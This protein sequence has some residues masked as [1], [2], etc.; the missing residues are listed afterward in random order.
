MEYVFKIKCFSF[1][2]LILFLKHLTAS[3]TSCT[4]RRRTNQRSRNR[5]HFLLSEARKK[6]TYQEVSKYNSHLPDIHKFHYLSS[7]HIWFAMS[8]RQSPLNAG[9]ETFHRSC[10]W[11]FRRWGYASRVVEPTRSRT[12]R[13]CLFQFRWRTGT[14]SLTLSVLR[15]S[16]WRTHLDSYIYTS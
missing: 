6:K 9:L 3:A 11:T 1:A 12:Q 8:S 16:A 2:K 5:W 15:L 10:R 4:K 13:H 14:H 7:A